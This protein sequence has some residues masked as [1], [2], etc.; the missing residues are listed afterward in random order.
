MPALGD[1][2]TLVSRVSDID[3]QFERPALV[4]F[5]F[6]A[7]TRDEI[8]CIWVKVVGEAQF[9]GGPIRVGRQQTSVRVP[10]ESYRTEED[11]DWWK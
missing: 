2:V 3:V 1:C 11:L 7:S 8:N 5:E 10:H 9:R 6:L 4:T